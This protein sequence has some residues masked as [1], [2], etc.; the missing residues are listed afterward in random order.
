MWCSLTNGCQA[1][2]LLRRSKV[3]QLDQASVVN[4]DVGAF[5]VPVHDAVAV[6][7]LQARQDLARVDFDDRLV[8]PACINQSFFGA[9]SGEAS[10]PFINFD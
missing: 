9:R 5:D 1:L 6:Q 3:G 7:V 8:E 2:D 10:A 4:Q